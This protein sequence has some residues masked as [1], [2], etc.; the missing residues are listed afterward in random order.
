MKRSETAYRRR[1]QVRGLPLEMRKRRR[2]VRHVG[3]HQPLF[4]VVLAQDLVFAQVK[5]IADAE[6]V[7]KY[8]FI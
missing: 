1:R 8:T 3:E 7:E 6:S 2:I 5:P 4:V